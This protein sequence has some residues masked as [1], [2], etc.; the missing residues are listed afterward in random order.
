MILHKAGLNFLGL[1]MLL[2]KY[3]S[4][5]KLFFLL[6]MT[7]SQGIQAGW[8]LDQSESSVEFISIKNNRILETHSFQKL[9]GSITST[10]IANLTIGLDGV[11][12]KIQI[13]DERMRNFLFETKLFP[14]ATFSAQIP[15]AELEFRDEHFRIGEVN[16]RLNL[17]GMEADLKSKVMILHK[18]NTLR[19]ITNHPI[20]I[21]AENFNLTQ[22]IA[23]LQEIAGLD[24]I[25]SV[26][27]VILDLVF[28]EST[29]DTK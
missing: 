6:L 22:G 2:F 5:T 9:S 12:T 1:N 26:V 24:S 15:I 20:L 27:P 14:H 25:S 7:T 23:R 11:S 13:R 29:D 4:P 10:G 16:G 28:V 18:N 8:N 3:L 19:I 17:H 21:S